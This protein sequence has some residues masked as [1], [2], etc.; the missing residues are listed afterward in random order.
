[1]DA[2]TYPDPAV[3]KEISE[4]FVPA[5]LE[6]AKHIE[7]S[8]KLNVRWLP[9]LV[10]TDADERPAHLVV[11]F[12]PPRDLLPELTF[13][14]A[15]LAM[16]E[17]RYDEAHELFRQVADAPG[18]ERAPEA[19]YWWGI[20]RVRQKKELDAAKE[21]WRRIVER[22]PESQWARKVG[23]LLGHPAV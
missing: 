16:G 1:M 7:L 17:K 3:E 19:C 23:Y 14:R 2:V 9:G 6:S 8:K 15:I 22:W 13:G 12:L 21:P 18:A 5:R 4:R 10:V 20:S 11:G